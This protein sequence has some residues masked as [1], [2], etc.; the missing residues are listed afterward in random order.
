MRVAIGV[1]YV[2]VLSALAAGAEQPKEATRAAWL[3][4]HGR[5]PVAYVV[6]KF[7]T[8]DVVLL[9]EMHEQADT[10]A[11]VTS[12]L[13]P[14][15][16]EAGVRLLISEF[17]RSADNDKLAALVT[18][19]TF[20]RDGAIDLMRGY[21]WPTWGFAEYLDI[22]E[23]VWRVNTGREAGTEP[24]L[25][26]GMDSDWRQSAL[27]A[28]GLTDEARMRLLLDREAHMVDVVRREALDAGRKAL[29]H[30]GFAH[31]LPIDPRLGAKLEEMAGERVWRVCLHMSLSE[32]QP[33]S[34]V[35]DAIEQAMRDLG[36]E[37]V[38]FDLTDGPIGTLR[39]PDSLYF[40]H[41]GDR[42]LADLAEG[43]VV[44]VPLE[45][46]RPVTW[47][48]GFI[49][50]A[51]FDEARQVAEKLGWVTPGSCQTP[52]DL[53]AAMKRLFADR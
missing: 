25:L 36:L 9:G 6:G 50:A 17:W 19:D 2:L 13:E 1:W 30:T 11:F 48:D 16:R 41:G 12:V 32:N 38:G 47:I 7:D 53:D 51:H 28:E 43:Y 33:R 49:D 42:T 46:M 10:L 31:A 20:D 52:A 29:V 27:M 35:S 37:R 45:R 15:Y 23:A 40:T 8:T 24:M 3:A 22:A 21:A 26:V 44:V 5:D 14:A 34:T 18:A 39:D 4:S